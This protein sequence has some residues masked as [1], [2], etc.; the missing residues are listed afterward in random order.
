MSEKIRQIRQ[1]YFTD[2]F[3]RTVC[4]AFGSISI[5]ALMGAGKIIFGLS[6]QSPWLLITALYALILCL[7]KGQILYRGGK[8]KD[9]TL[10]Q[11]KCIFR[12]SG[13]FVCLLAVSYFLVCLRMFSAGEANTYPEFLVYGITSTAFYK[14]VLAIYGV[15]KAGR[16]KNPVLQALKIFSLLDACVSI[17]TVQCALL[18]MQ[19]HEHIAT[20]SSGML[21]MCFSGM[22]LLTGISMLRKK[23]NIS[24]TIQ[25]SSGNTD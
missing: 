15:I 1:F 23:I 19:E 14:I 21:G 16:R 17:V 9:L 7:A 18:M 2:D 25:Q 24:Q 4:I 13:W 22:F 10:S 12:F 5:N 20:S 11:Q 8:I 3:S 6:Y